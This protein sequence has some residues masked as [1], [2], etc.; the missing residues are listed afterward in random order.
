MKPI[1][2]LSPQ[3]DL[4]AEID[5]YEYLSY[6]SSWYGV[7]SF[8]LR[9]NKYKKHVQH[10]QKQNLIMLSSEVENESGK[11]EVSWDGTKVCLINNREISVNQS[12]KGSETWIIRGDTLKGVMKYRSTIPPVGVAYDNKQGNTETVMHHYINNNVINPVDPDRKIDEVVLSTNQNR[13]ITVSRQSRHKNLA[14]EIEEIATYSELGWQVYLDFT[15]KKYVFDVSTGKDLTVNQNTNPPV[16]FSPDFESVKSQRFVDSDVNYKNVG[17]IGG[18]GEGTAR[19]II[20]IGNATGLDRIETFID[21]RDV[22]DTTSLQERGNQK[23]KEFETERYLEAEIMTPIKRI[24]YEREYTFL[25]STQTSEHTNRKFKINSS[26]VYEKDF[27]LGD[28]VTIQN[29]SWGVTMDARITGLKEIYEPSGFKLEATFGTEQ[30][31]F[32]TKVSQQYSQ[33]EAEVKR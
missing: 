16:I 29:R 21:A 12:G 11:V 18:Q 20:Q 22:E 32:L 6:S 14:E 19:E 13:G 23:M 8:E 7:G 1:R 30:P 4:L 10:L 31:T 15:S 3:M 27:N 33:I 25:S 9:I 24:E 17:Y 28:V 26:F 5:D 2:I